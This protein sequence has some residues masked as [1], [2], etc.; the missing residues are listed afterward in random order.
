[1]ERES[2]NSAAAHYESPRPTANGFVALLIGLV[3]LAGGAAWVWQGV[4]RGRIAWLP[5]VGGLVVIAIGALTLASL[6]LNGERLKV[7]DKRGN[8]VDSPA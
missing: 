1:M 6:Y 4:T 8:P 5:F 7:S 2:R 3:L